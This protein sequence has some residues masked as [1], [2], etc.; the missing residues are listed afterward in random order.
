MKKKDIEMAANLI[1]S[2]KI[3]NIAKDYIAQYN[4]IKNIESPISILF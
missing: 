4:S 1:Q 3:W 2:K